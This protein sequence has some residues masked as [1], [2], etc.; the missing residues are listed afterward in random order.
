M[1][2]QEKEKKKRKHYDAPAD[3]NTGKADNS[4]KSPPNK[5]PPNK[6]NIGK[7]ATG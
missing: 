3:V 6:S 7:K 4:K 5:S 2:G 1:L